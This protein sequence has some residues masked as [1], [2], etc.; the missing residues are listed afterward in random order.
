LYRATLDLLDVSQ[1]PDALANGARLVSV[2]RASA[3][4]IKLT[5]SQCRL[6]YRFLRCFLQPTNKILPPRR[7]DFLE[8]FRGPP[9]LKNGLIQMIM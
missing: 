1:A 5:T 9:K 8:K 3:D 2:P 6:F 4:H 7:A